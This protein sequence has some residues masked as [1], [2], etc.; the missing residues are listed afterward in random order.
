[1]LTERHC[2]GTGEL[3]V[4]EQEDRDEQAEEIATTCS[5]SSNLQE[6]RDRLCRNAMRE[7][8]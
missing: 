5:V 1:V 6:L 7:W 2:G 4:K 3:L 8:R